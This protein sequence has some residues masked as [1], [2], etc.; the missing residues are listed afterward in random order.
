MAA[1][2]SGSRTVEGTASSVACPPRLQLRRAVGCSPSAFLATTPSAVLRLLTARAAVPSV[3]LSAVLQAV[4]ASVR[5][6]AAIRYRLICH[7]VY[8]AFCSSNGCA[9][10]CAVLPTVGR[11]ICGAV[12]RTVSRANSCIISRTVRSAMCSSICCVFGY[13]FYRVFGYVFYHAS[14]CAAL[15]AVRRL[16][17]WRL[18]LRPCCDC[19]LLGRRCRQS[20]CRQ[21]CRLCPLQQCAVSWPIRCAVRCSVCGT[22]WCAIICAVDSAVRCAEH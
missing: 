13:V 1:L 12:Y 14:S 16:P 11:T 3:A 22:F 5:Q 10:S 2:W 4:S 18:H 15:S 6:S 17:F 19:S 20:R 9:I 8:C 7:T 21:C